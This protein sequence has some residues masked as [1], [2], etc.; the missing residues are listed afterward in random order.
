M[1]L[2][3]SR[4]VPL[5]VTQPLLCSLLGPLASGPINLKYVL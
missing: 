3:C 5:L 4:R 2:R 1:Q